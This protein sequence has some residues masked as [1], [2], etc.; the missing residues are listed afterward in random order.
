MTNEFRS[1]GDV[2][3]NRLGFGAMRLPQGGWNGPPRDPET[4]RA[5]LVVPSILASTTSIRPNSIVVTTA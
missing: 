1:G 5:V 4:G 3:I 2:P